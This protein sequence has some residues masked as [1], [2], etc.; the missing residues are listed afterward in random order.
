V[1]KLYRGYITELA[2]HILRVY[3]Y[4]YILKLLDLGVEW[5]SRPLKIVYRGVIGLASYPRM[6]SLNILS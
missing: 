4:I 3:Y 1:K 5:T 6:S 2:S